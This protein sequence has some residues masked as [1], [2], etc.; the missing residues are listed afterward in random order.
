MS[1]IKQKKLKLSPLLKKMLISSTVLGLFA[2]VGTSMVAF[3]FEN[4]K[5]Q[6]KENHRLATLRSLHQLV[7]P[8]EHDNDIFTDTIQ[9]TNLKLLGSKEPVTVFRARKNNKPVA[10]ILSAIAPDGYTGKITLLVAINF[11]GK[12]AGVRVVNHK[13]TPGLGDAIDIEKSNWILQFNGMSLLKPS[14]KK[15][16]VKRDGGYFDQL[17]G[18]TITPRAIVKAVHKALLFYKQQAAKLFVESET[19]SFQKKNSP[20]KS[21]NDE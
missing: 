15:W 6:I 4:T 3:T 17:T 16:K 1:E 19:K 21:I 11:N 7:P 14:H 20:N 5:E 13:E 12:L 9:V 10:A 8:S 18:A 2:I